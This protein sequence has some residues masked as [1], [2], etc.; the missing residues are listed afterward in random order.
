LKL[1]LFAGVLGAAI[2][3]VAME[4]F[5]FGFDNVCDEK[6]VLVLCDAIAPARAISILLHG[7][8]ALGRG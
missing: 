6:G 4:Y 2:T 5:L 3:M 1:P 8:L 7:L